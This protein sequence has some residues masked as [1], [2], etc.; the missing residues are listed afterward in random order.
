M[1]WFSAFLAFLAI[2]ASRH[3]LGHLAASGTFLGLLAILAKKVSGRQG[4]M[5]FFGSVGPT[6]FLAFV[7]FSLKVA[8]FSGLLIRGC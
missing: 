8:W 3:L 4:K 7:K 5:R 1:P 6:A 2:R